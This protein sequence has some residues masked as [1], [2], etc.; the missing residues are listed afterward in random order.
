[1]CGCMEK[2]SPLGVDR[3]RVCV[4]HITHHALID[5]CKAKNFDLSLLIRD[6]HGPYTNNLYTGYSFFSNPTT[7]ITIDEDGI[8]Y[9]SKPK[10]VESISF[11]EHEI[12]AE[13]KGDP[14]NRFIRIG[15]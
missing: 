4:E 7:D 9:R 5:A 10:Y 15:K 3:G 14:F 11:W 12:V 2:F 6:C 13:T 8:E 1:M